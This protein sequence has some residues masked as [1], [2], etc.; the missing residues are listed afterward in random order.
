MEQLNIISR[1]VSTCCEIVSE[2]H[3][4]GQNVDDDILFFEFPLDT[5]EKKIATLDATKRFEA[6]KGGPASNRGKMLDSN[7]KPDSHVRYSH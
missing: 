6:K 2:N 7:V 4:I 1:F 3:T 5:Q